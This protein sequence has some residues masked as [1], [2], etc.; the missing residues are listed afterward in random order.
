[1]TVNLIEITKKTYER[2][3]KALSIIIAT[4]LLILGFSV[5]AYVASIALNITNSG[6]GSSES[7]IFTAG[8]RGLLNILFIVLAIGVGLIISMLYAVY[9]I[10]K[11]RSKGSAGIPG[12]EI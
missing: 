2:F 7:G 1:M 9:V 6:T 3:S 4:L 5:I 11:L 12:E 8:V 10:D